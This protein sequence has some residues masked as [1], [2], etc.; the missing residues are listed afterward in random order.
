MTR[1]VVDPDSNIESH[2][3]LG[4]VGEPEHVNRAVLD[5]VLK[6]ELIPVLAPV[7]VG[8]DGETYNVNADTFAGA[9]AGA[10]GAKRL[11][12]LTDVPGV[13]DKN[14]NLIPEMT[15]DDCR[16]LIADGTITDG[17]IPKIET[18]IYALE[19]G[20]EAVVILDGKVAAFGAAGAVHRPRCRYADPQ[21]IEE[22]ELFDAGTAEPLFGRA[23][24]AALD[25]GGADRHAGRDRDRHDEPRRGAAH[26]QSLRVAQ[27]VRPD[28]ARP[29]PRPCRD[30]ERARCAALR[31]HARL[32]APRR[33]GLAYAL[34]VLFILVPL[35]GWIATSYCC[36]PVKFFWT[37]PVSLPIPDAPTMEAA[38]WIFQIHIGLAI[39][40][41][42][43]VAVHVAG[44]LQ[45]HFIRRDRTLLR[46]LPD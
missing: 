8:S 21:G 44:A 18:C 33:A 38:G 41:L 28:G 20:V 11:L 19:K 43:V 2:V 17:M 45:H 9:I 4:F 24:S 23:E 3:D 37:V 40:L 42:A 22:P 26:Q 29:R 5:A 32:A 10:M 12:L 35:I 34:Y 6:A 39:A 31:A 1:T 25:D 15:M 27:V 13:L 14:K 36:K 30:Q 16:R 46:M 7:A